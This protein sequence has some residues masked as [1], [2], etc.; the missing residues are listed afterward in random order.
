MDVFSEFN[1]A[2][3]N[4]HQIAK[5][6]KEGGKRVFGYIYSA[7]PEELIYAAGILPV[8]LIASE[9]QK[10]VITGETILPE[11]LCDYS[12]SCL[13][14]FLEGT[15]DYLD[16]LVI[17]DACATVRTLWRAWEVHIKIPYRYFFNPPFESSDESRIYY[18]QEMTR[19]KKSLEDFCGKKISKDDLRSAIEVYN[20]NR[21]LMQELYR[22]R[23]EGEILISANQVLEVVRAGLIMPKDEHNKMLQKALEALPRERQEPEGKIP[24]FLSMVTFEHCMTDDL[25]IPELIEQVGGR[26]VSDDLWMGPRYFSEPVKLNSELIEALVDRYLGKIPAGFRYPLELRLDWLS[27]QIGKHNIKGGIFVIPKYC[28]PYLFEYPYIERKLQEKGIPTLFLESEAGMPGEPLRVR[29][30]AFMEMLA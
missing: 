25:N 9:D 17:P 28:H 2:Y 19:F 22:L 6:W 18:T 4:R 16:G 29:L 24:L 1:E 11:F 8:Q 21:S 5:G 20:K 14:Q 27:V 26:V 23:S 3:Q 7:A 10:T 12:Q 30:Q 13:G 15:Y